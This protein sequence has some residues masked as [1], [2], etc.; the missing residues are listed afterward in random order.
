MGMTT[1]LSFAE[2]KEVVV[3]SVFLLPP[4]AEVS[5]S[6]RTR[7]TSAADMPTDPSMFAVGSQGAASVR[8]SLYNDQLRILCNVS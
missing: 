5:Y 4:L 2:R 8:L 6:L 3:V 1:G 7:P